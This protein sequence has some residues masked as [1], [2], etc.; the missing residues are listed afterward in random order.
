MLAKL[1][2]FKCQYGDT[3]QTVTDLSDVD[4]GLSQVHCVICYHQP[5]LGREQVFKGQNHNVLSLHSSTCRKINL[6]YLGW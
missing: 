6:I 5:A 1:V 4:R 3:C 2:L